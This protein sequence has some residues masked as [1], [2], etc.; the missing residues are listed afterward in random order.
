MFLR[1][2]K[3]DVVRTKRLEKFTHILIVCLEADILLTADIDVEKSNDWFPR[4]ISISSTSVSRYFV[5]FP[6]IEPEN[7]VLL[8]KRHSPIEVPIMQ[9]QQSRL[10]TVNN[11]VF[12]TQRQNSCQRRG[13]TDIP[14]LVWFL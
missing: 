8:L 1:L 12:I 7:P 3:V 2:G 4:V 14:K 10:K 11:G 9:R 6:R 5:R 13:H